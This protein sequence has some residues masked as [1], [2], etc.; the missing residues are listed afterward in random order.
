MCG[1]LHQTMPG[2]GVRSH[3]LAQEPPILRFASRSIAAKA[4][5]CSYSKRSAA[6]TSTPPSRKTVVTM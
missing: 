5:G 1:Q 4:M 6:S 3:H 2:S